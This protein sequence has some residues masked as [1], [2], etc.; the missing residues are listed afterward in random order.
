MSDLQLMKFFD[1]DESELQVNRN[2]RPSE[3]QK[4]RLIKNEKG[5]KGRAVGMGVFIFIIALIGPAIALGMALSVGS[6]NLILTI[7]FGVGFGFLWPLIYAAIGYVYM[8][9]AFVKMDIQVKNA[10]GPINVVKSVRKSYNVTTHTHTEYTVHELHVGGRI[11]EVAPGLSNIM[12]RGDVYAV[13]CADFGS[14]EKSQVL[15]AELLTNVS[16]A[17][18]PQPALT[19]DAEVIEYLK[20]DDTLKAIKAHRTIHNS[21]FE[22]ARSVVED[23]KSRLGY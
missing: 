3:K 9:R 20:K 10:E 15:S 14:K 13:Y 22:E 17:Y 19:D 1:F 4:V 2:G 16:A 11:F 21:S 6:E 18:A 23:I 7:L 12:L 8:R 5:K